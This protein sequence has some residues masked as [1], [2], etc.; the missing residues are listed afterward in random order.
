[1]KPWWTQGTCYTDDAKRWDTDTLTPGLELEE[2]QALCHG[3]P[4]IQKCAADAIKPIR[5][6]PV[7]R[8]NADGERELVEPGYDI[9]VTGVVRAGVPT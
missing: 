5:M 8:L 9:T 2:A 6:P 4:V 7:Y 1:M 3:C